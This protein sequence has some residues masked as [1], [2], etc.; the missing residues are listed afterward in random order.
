MIFFTGNIQSLC[1]RST[2]SSLFEFRSFEEFYQ[3]VSDSMPLV[4]S[5][6]G[7][8]DAFVASANVLSDHLHFTLVIEQSV[9]IK[10]RAL[11]GRI[12]LLS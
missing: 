12:K 4:G 10:K 9:N 1:I 8:I 2:V 11:I 5:A 3:I 6:K 7:L